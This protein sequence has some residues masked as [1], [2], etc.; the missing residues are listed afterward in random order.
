MTREA[1]ATPIAHKENREIPTTIDLVYFLSTQTYQYTNKFFTNSDKY[2][3]YLIPTTLSE[4]VS[5]SPLTFI[6]PS[7][8]AIPSF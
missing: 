8:S 7:P 6:K 4:E 5:N 1:I 3:M 2:K